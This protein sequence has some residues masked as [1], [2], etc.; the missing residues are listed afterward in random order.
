MVGSIY[1]DTA[2]EFIAMKLGLL[3]LHLR[4]RI[5]GGF[6]DRCRRA[7]SISLGISAK[8]LYAKELE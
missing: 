2:Y 3:Y 7:L 5:R 6:S 4:S 8:N 1:S